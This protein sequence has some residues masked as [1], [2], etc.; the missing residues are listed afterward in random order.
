METTLQTTDILLTAIDLELKLLL[1]AEVDLF[2]ASKQ[3]LESDGN[4]GQNLTV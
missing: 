1:Q 4:I 3:V 2:K